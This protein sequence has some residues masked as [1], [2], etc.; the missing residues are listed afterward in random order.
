MLEKAVK[1][2]TFTH[3]SGFVIQSSQSHCPPVYPS[4]PLRTAPGPHP[5]G[6]YAYP[7]AQRGNHKL[8]QKH[9]NAPSAK[10]GRSGSLAALP[11][12]VNVTA[13]GKA[14]RAHQAGKGEWYTQRELEHT[15]RDKKL[16]K[17]QE[18]RTLMQARRKEGKGGGGSKHLQ[19]EG[20]GSKQPDQQ[21]VEQDREI[22][23]KKF[24]FCHS[25]KTLFSWYPFRVTVFSLVFQQ[26]TI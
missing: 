21:F 24:S 3:F 7:P 15:Q 13:Q 10:Q 4:D 12:N 19:K 11:K 23:K 1:H 14:R 20:G 8:N 17:K 6:G 22:F 2:V 9:R 5:A 25:Q 16:K 18:D 26:H